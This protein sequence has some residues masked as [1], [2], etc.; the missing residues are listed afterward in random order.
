M[1]VLASKRRCRSAVCA[2]DL[3]VH[4]GRT[5]TGEL[6]GRR[7]ASRLICSRILHQ[8]GLLEFLAVAQTLQNTHSVGYSGC[9]AS[10]RVPIGEAAQRA[11]ISC[12]PASAHHGSAHL[13]AFTLENGTLLVVP[14]ADEP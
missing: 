13:P 14:L 8:Y 6:A 3:M 4:G 11:Q 7:N 2:K 5:N 12:G 1:A 9:S 10:S